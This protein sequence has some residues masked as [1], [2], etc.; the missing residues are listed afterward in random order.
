[1]V[2]PIKPITTK[3]VSEFRSN[4]KFEKKYFLWVYLSGFLS[5]VIQVPLER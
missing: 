1:M 3:L 4:D 2:K 5:P